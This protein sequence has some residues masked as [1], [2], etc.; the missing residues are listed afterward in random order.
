MSGAISGRIDQALG[1]ADAYGRALRVL[2]DVNTW[3]EFRDALS[4]L[5]QL[6]ADATSTI[7]ALT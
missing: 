2:E 3:H 5:K 6:K 1:R 7:E 4:E